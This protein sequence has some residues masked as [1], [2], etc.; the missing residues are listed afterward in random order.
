MYRV[1]LLWA[2]SDPETGLWVCLPI[3][4]LICLHSNPKSLGASHSGAFR[5][6][7]LRNSRGH[8]SSI[9]FLRHLVSWHEQGFRGRPKGEEQV[10][11]MVV[12][13]WTSTPEGVYRSDLQQVTRCLGASVPS[14]QLG[15]FKTWPPSS[16]LL[17]PLRGAG[18][19]AF[20]CNLG[21]VT[22]SPAESSTNSALPVSEP[23]PFKKQQNFTLCLLGYS[24]S[25]PSH[26]AV[27]KSN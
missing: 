23:R 22:A 10:S 2:S 8:H 27:R 20:P 5:M 7:A 25:G 3:T 9:E 16:L 18:L 11:E 14:S 21:F 6:A 24:F 1:P 12:T 4:V 13:N 19:C 26:H 15:N 17:F